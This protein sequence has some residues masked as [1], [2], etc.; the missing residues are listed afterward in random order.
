MKPVKYVLHT[1]TL[2]TERI[3]HFSYYLLCRLNGFSDTSR[4]ESIYNRILFFTHMV[5]EI[6]HPLSIYWFDVWDTLTFEGSVPR[7]SWADTCFEN[8]L[9]H[10]VKI[11]ALA[12]LLT[13]ISN[14]W[15]LFVRLCGTMVTSQNFSPRSSF[16]MSLS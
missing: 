12:G 1:D 16:K 10:L 11:N 4:F 14:G 6:H 13:D 8:Y 3:F 7:V 5:V 2:L 15:S 9:L